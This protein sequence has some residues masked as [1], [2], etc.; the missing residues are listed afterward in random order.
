MNRFEL[1]EPA[2]LDEA[3]ALLDPDDS[4]VRA[5]AGATALIL[6]M[7]ARLFRPSRLVS[8]RR[9]QGTLRGVHDEPAGGL[10]IG[11]LT[12]LTDLE[13]SD[14]V[15]AAAP[16][17]SRALR[18]LSNVRVRNVATLGGHLAHGD[19]HMDLPPILMT[20]G[21]RVRVVSRRGDRWIEMQDLVRG[22]YVTSIANDELIADVHLPAQPADAHTW[23]EKF[24]ALSADDWPTVGVAVWYRTGAGRITDARLA[25]G[26]A[27]E[28]PMRLAAAEASLIGAAADPASF[29]RAADA[30]ADAIEPL[31]DIRGSAAYKREMVRVHVRRALDKGR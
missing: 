25:V 17:V 20:L 21:A 23:Y 27:T 7:K 2:T 18:T 30:A 5:V 22:Y 15:R 14:R 4:A 9:L 13:R 3:V 24:T 31:A 8:L 26:A 1:V 12:T 29:A 16:V 19:P 28:R 10:R 11:A 6:M